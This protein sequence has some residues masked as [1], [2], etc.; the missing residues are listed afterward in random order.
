MID[1]LVYA[2]LS[3]FSRPVTQEVPSGRLDI[4]ECVLGVSPN[5]GRCGIL[6]TQEWAFSGKE[7]N[8]TTALQP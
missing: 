2:T 1:R 6:Y 5:R 8:T 7:N 3:S 4:M